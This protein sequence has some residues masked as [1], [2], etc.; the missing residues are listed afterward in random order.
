MLRRTP[1]VTFILCIWTLTLMSCAFACAEEDSTT[2]LQVEPST[3]IK[4]PCALTILLT[5]IA[6]EAPLGGHPREP[7]YAVVTS[8]K[9][10]SKLRGRIPDQAIEAGIRTGELNDNLILIAFAG[11]K[12]SSGYSITFKRVV[13]EGDY[14]LFLRHR[15]YGA[16]LPGPCKKEGLIPQDLID[17]GIA[18]DLD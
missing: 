9:E 10:W 1:A 14:Q 12:P 15:K 7:L 2:M 5:G 17:R 8:S 13:Q 18:S 3:R 16:I 6:H 11:T 4:E